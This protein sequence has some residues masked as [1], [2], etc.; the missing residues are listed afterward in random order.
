MQC[1]A[2]LKNEI[3]IYPVAL[4]L[5]VSSKK[6]SLLRCLLFLFTNGTL[7]FI[8]L[9]KKKLPTKR[10]LLMCEYSHKISLH[11]FDAKHPVPQGSSFITQVIQS[12]A[13]WK[14]MFFLLPPV[15]LNVLTSD[16]FRSKIYDFSASRNDDDGSFS[17]GAMLE[18]HLP[19]LRRLRTTLHV[20]REL[21]ETSASSVCF[22]RDFRDKSHSLRLVD[23]VPTSLCKEANNT[24]YYRNCNIEWDEAWKVRNLCGVAA[25]SSR[26]T[27]NAGV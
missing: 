5:L 6:L 21:H 1:F 16:V 27:D 18:K 4:V 24:R 3:R 7:T 22:M 13:T 25:S 10:S 9:L 19:V 20:L 23:T 15:S 12:T 8:E 11:R 17:H 2:R 14:S 26:D